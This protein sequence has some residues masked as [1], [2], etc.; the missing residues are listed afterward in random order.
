M[1]DWEHGTVMSQGLALHYVRTGGDRPPVVLVHGIT[2]SAAQWEDLAA[3]LADSWDVVMYDA[4]GHGQSDR[5]PSGYSAGD[6]AADLLNLIR[7]LDLQ[8]PVLLGHSMG[9]VTVAQ[10]AAQAPAMIRAVIMEDPAFPVP[11]RSAPAEPGEAWARE[12]RA[13]LE[14]ERALPAQE[15]RAAGRAQHPGWSD[16]EIEHWAVA[17][18]QLDPVVLDWFYARQPSW[19]E[20]LAQVV[21]PTLLIIGEAS[22]GGIVTPETA[23]AMRAVLPQGEV[24]QIPGAGHSIRREQFARYADTVRTFL[25]RQAGQSNDPT[26]NHERAHDPAGDDSLHPTRDHS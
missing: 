12:W 19:R 24:V 25:D 17:K 18:E 14:R 8:R 1:A 10:A 22:L 4:R 21:C 11:G 26:D 15:L 5:P 3:V 6:H 20:T 2:D 23:A 7:A 13:R 9:G 16:R